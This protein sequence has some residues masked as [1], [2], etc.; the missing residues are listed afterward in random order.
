[1]ECAAQH[2]KYAIK[3]MA[4]RREKAGRDENIPASICSFDH[5]SFVCLDLQAF[6]IATKKKERGDF[7]PPNDEELYYSSIRGFICW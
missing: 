1:M 4:W 7:C 5:Q 2:Y 3:Q 6:E